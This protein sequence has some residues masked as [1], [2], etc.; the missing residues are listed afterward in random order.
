MLC[1]FVAVVAGVVIAGESHAERLDLSYLPNDTRWVLHLDI[2][3]L[4]DA[5]LTRTILLRVWEKDPSHREIRNVATLLGIDLGE[6]LHSVTFLGRNFDPDDGAMLAHVELEQKRVLALFQLRDDYREET[7]RER[8]IHVWNDDNSSRRLY[9]VFLDDDRIIVG[10]DRDTVKAVL[11][12]VAGAAPS[13]ARSSP[14]DDLAVPPG[15]I[16]H[17]WFE[18]VSGVRLPFMSPL[19][20]RV[21]HATLMIGESGQEVFVEGMVRLESASTAVDLRD[22]LTGIVAIGKLQFADE[23]DVVAL[24][25][26]VRLTVSGNVVTGIW[27]APRQSVADLLTKH[28]GDVVAPDAD[29]GNREK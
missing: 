10:H 3:A 19:I 29:Q 24:L 13:W 1:V 26:L 16:V 18:K 25:N 20:R 28:F 9:G 22:A 23:T 17:L 5:E 21:Q 6:D 15:T 12:V 14:D 27:R 4:K 11:D 7:Y 2:D 8:T